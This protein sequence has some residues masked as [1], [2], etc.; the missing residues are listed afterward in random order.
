M[1]ATLISHKA[2]LYNSPPQ[3]L[4]YSLV[5]LMYNPTFIL[6]VLIEDRF[7]TNGTDRDLGRRGS[8]SG[9]QFNDGKRKDHGLDPLGAMTILFITMSRTHPTSISSRS[10]QT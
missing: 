6:L 8:C 5:C 2:E 4:S 7:L 1:L 3:Q 10:L 9:F